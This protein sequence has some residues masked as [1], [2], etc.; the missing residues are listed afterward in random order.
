MRKIEEITG[1]PLGA[2]AQA[3]RHLPRESRAAFGLLLV[4]YAQRMRR[5][6]TLPIE[7]APALLCLTDAEFERFLAEA[8]AL[9][10]IHDSA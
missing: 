1:V 3:V 4:R 10:T 9:V 7:D 8:G 6:V 2:L 5:G